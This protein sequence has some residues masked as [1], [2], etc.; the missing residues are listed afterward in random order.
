M[1]GLVKYQAAVRHVYPVFVAR[2]G[3]V[4]VPL[5]CLHVI[6]LI[7]WKTRRPKAA[8][9]LVYQSPPDYFHRNEFTTPL[10]GQPSGMWNMWNKMVGSNSRILALLH[11]LLHDYSNPH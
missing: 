4:S 9:H 3:L 2:S 5:K 1:S 8:C 11:R 10:P 7:F 6:R